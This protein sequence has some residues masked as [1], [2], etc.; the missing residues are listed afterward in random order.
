MTV[1]P[2]T[3]SFLAGAGL[4]IV[5]GI[6]V[7]AGFFV[8]R[9]VR[10]PCD[11][12]DLRLVAFLPADV[13]LT[14]G[15]PIRHAGR[16]IGRVTAVMP[17]TPAVQLA[18]E[19]RDGFTPS[20]V[21]TVGL[22][23]TTPGAVRV[24][25]AVAVRAVSRSTLELTRGD[26]NVVLRRD[27]AGRWAFDGPL[28]ADSIPALRGRT[29]LVTGDVLY[30]GAL[31][32]TWTDLARFTMVE[33]YVDAGELADAVAAMGNAA[34]DV[35]ALLG[36]GTSL[37]VAGLAGIAG[38]ELTLRPAYG[39]DRF[40]SRAD[41]RLEVAPDLLLDFE[42]A[43]RGMSGYLTSPAKAEAPPTNRYERLVSDLNA[44][45][46]ALAATGANLEGITAAVEAESR[47]GRRG[48]VGRLALDDTTRDGLQQLL[49]SASAVLARVDTVTGDYGAKPGMLASLALADTATE[50]LQR[51]LDNVA[52]I[53][54]RLDT[55]RTLL[56]GLVGE[57]V[58]GD[59]DTA[60]ANIA[61]LTGQLDTLLQSADTLLPAFQRDLKRISPWAIAYGII[62][63][64]AQ[65]TAALALAFD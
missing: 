7:L 34:A 23:D 26:S 11:H 18:V 30:F 29:Y 55:G 48:F 54:E 8:L 21:V 41:G 27:A 14:A 45:L 5:T 13:E 49:T 63:A 3:K 16:C 52:G 46:E 37:V 32:V 9:A 31:R 47:V 12:Q 62:T 24:G 35:E 1:A 10:T 25:D 43:L 4:V 44:S 6:V 38:R 60:V 17:G 28:P 64:L 61:S 56:A 53:T 19:R 39:A 58:S 15:V 65:A 20:G 59:L 42:T 2:G 57:S 51:I 50:S 22:A 33:G 36:S 40:A